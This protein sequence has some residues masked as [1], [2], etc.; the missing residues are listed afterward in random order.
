LRIFCFYFPCY[1]VTTTIS[2]LKTLLMI[3]NQMI[4]FNGISIA[5]KSCGLG[6]DGI[7]FLYGS[8]MDSDAWS[9]Q[10]ENEELTN[11]YHLIAFDLPGNGK[12]GWYQNDTT[13]YRPKKMGLLVQAIVERY[14]LKKFVLVGLSYGTNIIGEI[15]PPLPGCVGI[16]LESS[17]IVN[18]IVTAR[19]MDH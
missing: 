12:S 10:F 3:K 6:E 18:D 5:T 2:N 8:C 4:D 16:L 1:I 11:K 15:S 14:S 13:G 9:P 7:I 19:R 17:C